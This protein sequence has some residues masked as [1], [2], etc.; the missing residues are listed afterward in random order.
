MTPQSPF[1]VLAAVAPERERELREL[2]AS[3]NEAPG[4]ADPNNA[5]IPFGAF[6]RLHVARLLVLDDVTTGDIAAYDLPPPKPTLYFALLG[7]VDGEAEAFLDELAR[8]AAPG[9]TRLFSCCEGFEPGADL[10]GWLR[11]HRNPAVANY[12]NSLGR[13]VREIREEAR[14]RVALD[15]HLAAHRDTLANLPARE[16]HAALRRFVDAEKAAGRLALTA[17]DPTPFGWWLRDRLH[18]V[19]VPLLALAFSPL[20]LLAAPFYLLWLR[21]AE[22]TDPEICFN[23]AQAHSEA[24]S[25]LEDHDVSN[26]FSAMGS[27]K[28]GALRLLTI[29]GVLTTV[30]YAARHIVRRGRLGRIRSIH[31]AR[32][33]F[34]GG[35][36]RMAFFSN[37]DGSVESY[38]D[39]FINK[40][41]FGLNAV[42]GNGIGY[43]QTRW[44]FGGG[45]EDERKYKEYLR[46]HTLATQVWYKAY[47]GLTAVDLERNTRIRE[48]LEAGAPGEDAAR[49]WVALL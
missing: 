38:M 31:F 3:M 20:L 35:T 5:L 9:L 26:P 16:L 24:L 19:G 4:R 6:D 2:L 42:F 17:P 39:D 21:R 25:L 29:L 7:D 46:R 27:L 37:Y 30:D 11:R 23:V 48:G 45:C 15:A 44:L 36:E 13:T 49:E 14:L 43:P 34:V 8:R 28:P 41:G 47:P 40:A 10:A 18:L 33:V 22:R 1:M 12:V 32:W